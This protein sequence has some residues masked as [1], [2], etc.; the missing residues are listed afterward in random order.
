MG[1]D[2]FCIYWYYGI[3]YVLIL[4]DQTNIYIYIYIHIYIDIYYII[5]TI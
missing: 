1:F 5:Y 2:N 4:I 3:L